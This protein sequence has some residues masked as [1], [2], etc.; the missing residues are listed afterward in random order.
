MS[1]A[2]AKAFQ[3]VAAEEKS[4][5]SFLCEPFAVLSS[6]SPQTVEEIQKP[7]RPLSAYNFFFQ[8]ERV[9]LLAQLP[10][11]PGVRKPRKSHGKIGFQEMATVIGARWRALDDE[12]RAYFNKLAANDKLRYKHEKEAYAKKKKACEQNVSLT[13]KT[14]FK[15]G[16][17]V[18]GKLILPLKQEM[19]LKDD[20]FE[21]LPHED[22][23]I[24]ELAARLDDNAKKLIIRAFL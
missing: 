6:T 1:S 3:H 18:Y 22:P 2:L 23:A 12:T 15:N 16:K 24:A 4:L 11:R 10:D 5:D 9:H 20:F 21:P 19:T 17:Q 13:L 8:A 7:K 14:A